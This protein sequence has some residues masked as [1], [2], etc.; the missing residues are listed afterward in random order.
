S[1]FELDDELS[2]YRRRWGKLGERIR[3]IKDHRDQLAHHPV[4][5]GDA[6]N[7]LIKP[8]DLDIRTKSIRQKP[9]SLEQVQSF[10]KTVTTLSTDLIQLSREATL[11][12]VKQKS[13]SASSGPRAATGSQ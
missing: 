2:Q 6:D 5:M 9:L 8:S 1:L 10:S 4:Q 7:P 13:A 12:A 11:A 3:Q